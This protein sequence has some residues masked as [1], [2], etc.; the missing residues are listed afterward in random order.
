MSIVNQRSANNPN[1]ANSAQKYSYSFVQPPPAW[2]AS[3]PGGITIDDKIMPNRDVDDAANGTD[4]WKILRGVDLYFAAEGAYERYYASN[5]F[6]LPES[7]PRNTYTQV[8]NRGVIE[9]NLWHWTQGNDPGVSIKYG[10]A[11]CYDN[12]WLK[13]ISS[14]SDLQASYST[15]ANG[16]QID[17]NDPPGYFFTGRTGWQYFLDFAVGKYALSDMVSI[18]SDFD[19]GKPLSADAVRRVYYDMERLQWYMT[20]T[21]DGTSWKVARA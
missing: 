21:G 4:T 1:Y 3:A 9:S 16:Q 13:D 19:T 15:W 10:L 20:D 6:Q 7:W 18:Y 5:Q 11:N 12:L 2:S 8:R 14:A 17:G